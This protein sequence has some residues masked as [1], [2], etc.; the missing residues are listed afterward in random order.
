MPGLLISTRRRRRHLIHR[1]HRVL[2]LDV[3]GIHAAVLAV[4]GTVLGVGIAMAVAALQGNLG[5]V[6]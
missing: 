4:I 6:S 3:G 1:G 2:P 5:S